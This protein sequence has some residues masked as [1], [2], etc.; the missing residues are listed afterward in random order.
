VADNVKK[1][2]AI[3]KGTFTRLIRPLL[4]QQSLLSI[5]KVIKHRDAFGLVNN[6][7]ATNDD[8]AAAVCRHLSNERQ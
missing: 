7:G 2:L 6:R 1:T 3:N 5:A 8:I 4:Q